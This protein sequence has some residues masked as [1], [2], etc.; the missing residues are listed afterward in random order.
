VLVDHGFRLPSALDNRPLKFDEFLGKTK[1]V[2]YV[3]ATPGPFE[4]EHC[5]HMVEQIIRPTGLVDPLIEVRPTKGQI[6][7]LVGEINDRIQRDERVLVTT[8]TKKMSEDL[9]DY[10]KNL[11]LKVRYLHSEIKTLERVQILRQ[12]RLGVFDVLVGINLLR[13]GLDLPEVSLVTILDADKEGFLRSERSLIQTIGR[14]ARNADGR[15]IMYADRMTDSMVKAIS[16]TNRRRTIQTDYNREHGITPQTIRKKVLDAIEAT[17]VAEQQ[18]SYLDQVD[19]Q[20]LSKKDRTAL[21]SRLEKE[22]KEAAK[23]LQFERAAD[24]RDAILEL[25][26]EL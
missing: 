15:V 13:E 23:Q 4:L 21:I 12:L 10:M 7:D 2:V 11:G 24:L 14:A 17:K 8:L 6:D 22:M 18:A 9:T 19:A 25:K 20:N 1:Q 26:A 3:S 5:P 16:E